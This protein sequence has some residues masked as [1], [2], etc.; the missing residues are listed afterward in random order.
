MVSQ[1]VRHAYHFK[2]QP[3]PSLLVYIVLESQHVD[4]DCELCLHYSLT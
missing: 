4:L 3:H 1:S 2:L